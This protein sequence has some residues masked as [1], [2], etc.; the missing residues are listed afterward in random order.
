M[1]HD[2]CA[3]RATS[4]SPR[5]RTPRRRGTHLGLAFFF[6]LA[7]C[8][9]TIQQR[10]AVRSFGEA[11]RDFGHAAAEQ[12]AA[13]RSDVVQTNA[14]VL[15]FDHTKIKDP[16]HLDGG[17]TTEVVATRVRAAKALQA[18]GELLVAI[19]DDTQA[20]QLQDATSAFT[21]SLRGVDPAKVKVSDEQLDSIGQLVRTIGGW[22][23]EHSKKQAL[24][25]IIPR[26]T[27]HIDDVCELFAAEL[28]SKGPL[29]M[30][31]DGRGQLAMSAASRVLESNTAALQDR[32][33]A[34]QLSQQGAALTVKAATL[35]PKLHSGATQLIAAQAKLVEVL[36]TDATSLKDVTAFV[37]S[38]QQVVSAVAVLTK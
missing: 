14:G 20:S 34:A 19:V 4:P 11:A 1:T 18:Y 23:V 5:S 16:A 7:S 31:V 9:L 3:R 25:N 26:A 30:E 22:W 21:K 24:I 35:C 15:A 13:L 6:L 28:D 17:L 12:I 33:T 36:T 32:Q 38:V 37:T 29:A 10:E 2:L 27:T 8:G